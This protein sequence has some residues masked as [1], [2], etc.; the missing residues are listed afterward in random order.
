[1]SFA[2]PLNN[3]QLNRRSVALFLAFGAIVIASLL[4]AFALKQPALV[5]IPIAVLITFIAVHDIRSIYLILF[6]AIPMSVELD[7]QGG[8]S[9]NMPS[10]P[11]MI[12]LM[13]IFIFYIVQHPGQISYRFLMHPLI[14]LLFVHILWMAF[15][16]F[17]SEDRVTSLKFLAAKLWYITTF[18]LMTAVLIRGRKDFIPVFW[19]V[20]IPLAALTLLTLI[21]HYTYGF[22]F[23]N[24]NDVVG[25]Y[26]RN[27]VNYAALLSVF[28]PFVWFARYWQ[29]R[30]TLKHKLVHWGIPLLLAGVLF[31][32][33]R[34]AW[35]AIIIG[36]ISYFAVRFRAFV[37]VFIAGIALVALGMSSLLNS[38]RYL[39]FAPE[40][41]QTIYHETFGAHMAATA[42]GLQDVSSAERVYRWVAAKNMF[43]DRWILGVGPGNFYPYYKE[44]TARAFETY[45]SDNE[46]KSTVHNYFLLMLVEQG[47]VGFLIFFIVTLA[48][49]FYGQSIYH[50]TRK[51]ADKQFVM[52]LVLSLVILMV[53]N[54][55]NDLV[56]T[57]KVGSMFFLNI[58]LLVIMD[59]RS[60]S[61]A[62]DRVNKPEPTSGLEPAGH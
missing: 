21:R 20:F 2:K 60:R 32:L 41:E 19:C 3:P 13:L 8:L 24:V 28:L 50:R 1:M 37:P 27:H 44:Y 52:A 18:V 25:P 23:D 10:E 12:G 16:T 47:I 40:F 5:A 42:A 43:L 49:L 36:V 30:G 39:N 14:L 56:E 62:G 57:D 59:L 58:A 15:T 38:N 35:L 33:T 45:V 4:G 48:A 31:A 61:D 54:M 22:R 29:R 46:E 53:Q 34:G 6:V 55:L 9:T 26:F 7:F 11:L 51:R 17:Y